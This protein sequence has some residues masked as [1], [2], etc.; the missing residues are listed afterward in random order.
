M[1]I[2]QELIKEGISDQAAKRALSGAYAHIMSCQNKHMEAIATELLHKCD[3]VFRR[4]AKEGDS[5]Y[6]LKAIAMK[7][8]LSGMDRQDIHITT[9]D[10]ENIIKANTI[11]LDDL[12]KTLALKESQEKKLT[13]LLESDDE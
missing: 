1:E 7:S 13:E 11:D 12:N 8:K 5:E 4:S 2:I 3:L 10:D 6:M 9:H